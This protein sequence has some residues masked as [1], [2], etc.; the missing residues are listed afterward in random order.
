MAIEIDDFFPEH[1]QYMHV[2]VWDE[3]DVDILPHLG[4]VLLKKQRAGLVMQLTSPIMQTA[5]SP[6]LTRRSTTTRGCREG[7][8]CF[9]TN[10][11]LI[12]RLAIPSWR[13]CVCCGSMH[14]PTT[15]RDMLFARQMG[16]SRSA[17]AVLAWC[18]SHKGWSLDEAY[19]YVKKRRGV[20]KPNRWACIASGRC[21]L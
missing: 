3:P 2:Q 11:S 4:M 14:V 20:V 12:L 9:H 13:A 16:V 10:G 1:Y 19:A 18:I 17:T 7:H 15:H 21:S 8:T 6:L 5:R